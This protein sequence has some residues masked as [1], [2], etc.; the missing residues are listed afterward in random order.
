MKK[1]IIVSTLLVLII[2][3]S[4]AQ[5]GVAINATGAVADPSA[6]LDVSSNTKG[7]LTPR[8]SEAERI[9]IPSPAR[10]LL[11]YQIDNDSGFWFYDGANWV[12]ANAGDNLGN[13][14]ATTHLDMASNKIVNVATCT[15]NLD[16]AN[17]EYVDN[18]VAAGGGGP[19]LADTTYQFSRVLLLQVDYPS[20]SYTVPANR[21][22]SIESAINANGVNLQAYP[23][24][25][26]NINGNVIAS[27]QSITNYIYTGNLLYPPPFPLWLPEGTNITFAVGSSS[28]HKGWVSIREYKKV[29]Q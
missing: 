2:L 5:N 19:T 14:T 24:R 21:A 22:W 26:T 13:H 3:Q 11:V 18:A 25:I 29:I 4:F 27:Y 7:F 23:V 12:K 1:I 15:N 28:G 16:A 10:G 9:A 17:K 8:M 6:M 20:T